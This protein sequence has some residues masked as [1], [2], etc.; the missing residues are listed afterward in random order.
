MPAS[1]PRYG[2]FL[3]H[4]ESNPH[5][6]H[7][8]HP[9]PDRHLVLPRRWRMLLLVLALVRGGE[10]VAVRM[11]C[12]FSLCRWRYLATIMACYPGESFPADAPHAVGLYQCVRCK[13]LS[14]G[15]PSDP[16]MRAE[17]SH[18]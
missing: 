13:E 7:R 10:A 9:Q 5:V 15:A 11:L 6:L 14:L 2:P 4:S 1:G 16:A 17:E 18:E 8:L 3:N 12:W